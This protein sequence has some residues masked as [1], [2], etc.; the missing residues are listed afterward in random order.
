MYNLPMKILIILLLF[1]TTIIAA[2]PENTPSTFTKANKQEEGHISPIVKLSRSGICHTTESHSYH[3]VASYTAYS[4]VEACLDA[5]G[6]LPKQAVV[7]D[8]SDPDLEMLGLDYMCT[9][10]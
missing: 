7:I 9:D 8:C 4:T 1:S 3:S 2:E 6:R 5:G 10:R